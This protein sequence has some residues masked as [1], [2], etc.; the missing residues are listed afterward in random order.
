MVIAETDGWM[1][2]V[3]VGASPEPASVLV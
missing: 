2:T 3:F 1:Y